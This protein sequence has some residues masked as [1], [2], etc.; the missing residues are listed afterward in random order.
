VDTSS[1]NLK[2][3]GR[4]SFKVEKNETIRQ[5]EI[6]GENKISKEN[7][8]IANSF[9]RYL[10]AERNY[11]ENTLRAYN[12]DVLD[13]A[14][15]VQAKKLDFT[16]VSKYEVRDFLKR[17]NGKK[18]SKASIARKFASLRTLYFFL[19][20]NKMI[21]K[22]PVVVM[23][24]PKKDKKIPSFLTENEMRKIFDMPDMNLRDKV[25]FEILYSC[26]IRIEELAS[27]KFQ[28]VNF[29]SN[30]ISVFGKGRK[31]RTVP[32]GDTCLAII[33]KYM[34]EK[35]KLNAPAG[36]KDF[37]F[38][39]SQGNKLNQR[40]IRRALHKLFVKACINKKASPHTIRH[41]FA[42]HLLE[43][44]CDLRSVQEMLGHKNLSTTQIYTHITIENL[45]KIYEETHPRAKNDDKI[46]TE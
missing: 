17:L 15:F 9:G 2:R 27:L 26:G 11:S 18:L 43:N 37:V 29:F 21:E 1:Q 3:S 42:T 13:F 5:N 33:R 44:G 31:Y 28:D 4:E 8:E 6:N 39:N 25:M 10:I 22:D 46:F 30:T 45:R 35:K 36:E 19:T 38:T 41:S 7:Q 34:E 20:Q 24:S 14:S 40:M 23:T 12:R 16:K 32:I